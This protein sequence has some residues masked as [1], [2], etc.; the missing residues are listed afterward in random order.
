MQKI[1]HTSYGEATITF[2]TFATDSEGNPFAVYSCKVLNSQ[3]IDEI[4][5]ILLKPNETLT[6]ELVE[7]IAKTTTTKGRTSNRAK[8]D[9]IRQ[10][11]KSQK[12]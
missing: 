12:I 9:L 10:Q 3:G 11:I 4:P 1:F 2:K 5:S 7:Q 8:N 6:L